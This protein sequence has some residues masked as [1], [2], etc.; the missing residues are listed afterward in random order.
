[1]SSHNQP[2]SHNVAAEIVA[3]ALLER[4]ATNL[5]AKLGA[6]I[7]SR[8]DTSWLDDPESSRWI[9]KP[10]GGQ[11]HRESIGRARRFMSRAGWIESKRIFPQHI[12]DGAKYTT[13]HGTTSKRVLWKNLGLRSPMNRGSRRKQRV[14][15]ERI[16]RRPQRPQRAVEIETPARAR[17]AA[18]PPE[19]AA[20]LAG[21]GPTT[22][23][24]ARRVL[25]TERPIHRER[26]T[27]EKTAAKAAEAR[28]LLEQFDRER[29]RGPP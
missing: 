23:E 5:Q 29:D 7:A 8:G 27:D 11:Y 6:E 28:R 20:M 19:L 15:Q 18:I 3:R 26:L 13:P 24:P 2:G 14:E 12:P 1:M 21:I 25:R 4:G 17:H 10:G 9:V 16:T 22:T